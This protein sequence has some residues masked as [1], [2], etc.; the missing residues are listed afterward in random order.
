MAKKPIKPIRVEP[1]KTRKP[2]P[3]PGRP[4]PDRKKEAERRKAREKVRTDESED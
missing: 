4:M 2:L 3:P 1:P